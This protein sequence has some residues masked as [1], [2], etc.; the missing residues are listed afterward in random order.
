MKMLTLI[1]TYFASDWVDVGYQLIKGNEVEEI[2][3]ENTSAS[4]KCTKMLHV[5]LKTDDSASYKKLIDVLNDLNLKTAALK[6]MDQ[7]QQQ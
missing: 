3:N 5:W 2:Q 1:K 7:L 6:I 4:Q